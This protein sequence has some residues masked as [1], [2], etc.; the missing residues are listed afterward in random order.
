MDSEQVQKALA[1]WGDVKLY[2]RSLRTILEAAH[3]LVAV[4]EAIENEGP[5]PDI[6]REIMARH[7]KEWPTLWAA[8]E[9]SEPKRN[10][11]PPAWEVYG[12]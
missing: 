1:E 11:G 9:V 5:R 8:L 12:G 7:R 10:V 2:S 4:L 6:H 3:R